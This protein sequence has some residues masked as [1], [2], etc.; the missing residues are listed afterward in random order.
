MHAECLKREVRFKAIRSS[1]KGGQHVNKVSTRAVLTFQV[2][3]STCLSEEEKALL[4]KKLSARIHADGSI[5]LSC[6]LSRSLEANKR[7]VFE[8]FLAL[9]EKAL[10]TSPKRKATKP[11]KAALEKRIADKKK[12][13]ALK[14]ERR[15]KGER[16]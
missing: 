5:S 13:S 9:L 6:G 16:E 3:Q 11:G 7:Q 10:R 2:R 1:G 8:R 14:Q 15:Q 4:E 12:R